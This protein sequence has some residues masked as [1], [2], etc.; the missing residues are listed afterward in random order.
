MLIRAK[1]LVEQGK[2]A[3]IEGEDGVIVL[4]SGSS[5]RHG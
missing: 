2:L 4:T 3:E 1:K 5:R